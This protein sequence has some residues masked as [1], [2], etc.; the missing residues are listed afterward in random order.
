MFFGQVYSLHTP[1][2][3]AVYGL[4]IGFLAWTSRRLV[5]KS[6]MNRFSDGRRY[7]PLCDN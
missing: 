4:K 1:T 5:L 6:A 2:A 3:T 7:K